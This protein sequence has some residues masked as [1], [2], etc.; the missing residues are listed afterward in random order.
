[1][2]QSSKIQQDKLELRSVFR[3][4]IKDLDPLLEMFITKFSPRKHLLRIELKARQA[5]LELLQCDLTPQNLSQHKIAI[6]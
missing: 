1:M 4:V 2:Q 3:C 6:I 5:H